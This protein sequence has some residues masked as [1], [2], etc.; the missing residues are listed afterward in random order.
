LLVARRGEA[1]VHRGAAETVAVAHLDERHPGRVERRG[2]VAHLLGGDLVPLGMHP[3][4][5]AHVVERDFSSCD[6]HRSGSVQAAASSI[7]WAMTSAA[8]RP[9]AV[10]MS[11]LP[12]YFGR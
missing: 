8:R 12:A 5:E 10:M 3:V 6:R 4:A 1:V 11:R 2:D 7:C 9:A